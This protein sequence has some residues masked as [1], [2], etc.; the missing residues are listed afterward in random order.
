MRWGED[1]PAQNKFNSVFQQSLNNYLFN[2]PNLY[3]ALFFENS[4]L[5]NYRRQTLKQIHTWLKRLDPFKLCPFSIFFW[6][7][8]EPYNA[9]GVSILSLKDVGVYWRQQMEPNETIFLVF[10]ILRLKPP[11]PLTLLL[12]FSGAG[13]VIMDDFASLLKTAAGHYS[14]NVNKPAHLSLDPFKLLPKMSIFYPVIDG[15]TSIGFLTIDIRHIEISLKQVMEPNETIISL[16]RFIDVYTPFP[17]QL[18]V[19]MLSIGLFI[20]GHLNNLFTEM[21]KD[22]F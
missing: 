17:L 10:N 1:L 11:F 20:A 8:I 7:R 5:K 6:F 13:L 18:S 12:L 21:R 14:D 2:H 9:I 15:Y 19:M 3:K 4:P 16:I 22:L